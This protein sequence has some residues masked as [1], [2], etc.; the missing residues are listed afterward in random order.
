ML[1]LIWNP[2]RLFDLLQDQAING[3]LVL[4]LGLLGLSYHSTADRK[5]LL[6]DA[7]LSAA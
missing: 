7:V 2:K 1:F 5:G 4:I 6:A 3:M